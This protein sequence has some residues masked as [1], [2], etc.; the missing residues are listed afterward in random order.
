MAVYR[1]AVG[2][3]DGVNI[4]EHFGSSRAFRIVEID[5]ET[6]EESALAVI[7]VVHSEGC[8]HG[9]DQAMLEAKIQSLLDWQVTAVLVARIG[10]G[11]ERMLTKNGIQVLESE[12]SIENAMVK[13]K[14]FYKR[15][16]FETKGGADNAGE[17]HK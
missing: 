9:H 2:S 1:I 13:I 3:A 15:Y 4:T 5:Q 8:G 7:E 17:D 16:S 11:S 12:G 6:D 14:R 10:P